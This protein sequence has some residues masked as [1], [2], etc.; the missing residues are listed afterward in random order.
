MI[1]SQATDAQRK[2]SRTLTGTTLAPNVLSVTCDAAAD[3][4]NFFT[5]GYEFDH[6]TNNSC[7]LRKPCANACGAAA[8]AVI[9]KEGEPGHFVESCYCPAGFVLKEGPVKQCTL[10]DQ[11]SNCP[12]ILRSQKGCEQDCDVSVMKNGELTVQCS[13]FDGYVYDKQTD[14]CSLNE[15]LIASLNYTKVTN[16]TVNQIYQVNHASKSFNVVC[17]PGYYLNDDGYCTVDYC[18]RDGN[19]KSIEQYCGRGIDE[20]NSHDGKF[21][22]NCP[23]GFVNDKSTGACTYEGR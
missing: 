15:T 4:M 2:T 11:S 17:A 16:L 8:C 3:A 18:K 10:K 7:V 5:T 6:T 19:A 22:C 9:E 14:K 12:E 13:C 20:C 21:A 1:V 23:D